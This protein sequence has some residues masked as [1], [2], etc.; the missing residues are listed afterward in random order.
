MICRAKG[1]PTP[2]IKWY[3]REECNRKVSDKVRFNITWSQGAGT[4]VCQAKNIYGVANATVKVSLGRVIYPFGGLE[5]LDLDEMLII[6]KDG[7]SEKS[8]WIIIGLATGSG[9]VILAL[10]VTLLYLMR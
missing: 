10:T 4:Y 1:Y 6:R 3:K 8:R 2:E 7:M 5:D 9:I